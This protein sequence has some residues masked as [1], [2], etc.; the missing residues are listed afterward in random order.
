M[1]R[2]SIKEKRAARYGEAK[3]VDEELAFSWLRAHP[4]LGTALR[5]DQ[6]RW[7]LF[8]RSCPPANLGVDRLDWNVLA[9]V[10]KV[11]TPPAP[12]PS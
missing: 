5:D 1:S 8:C 6:K 2:F 3:K 10:T 4:A 9:G 12:H 7:G 11:L